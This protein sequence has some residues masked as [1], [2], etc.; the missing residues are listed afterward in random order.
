[1]AIE[2]RQQLKLSQQLIMTPQLQLAIKLLQLSRL[3]LLET[4]HQELQENPALEEALEDGATDQTEEAPEIIP[5][6]IGSITG[7]ISDHKT[8]DDTDWSSLINEYSS[9]GRVTSETEKKRRS[10]LRIFYRPERISAGPSF[11]AISDDI[12]ESGG[13]KPC[14]FD[15]RQS[16][17]RWLS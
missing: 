4:I 6:D 14:Q 8:V 2:L 12:S 11:L 15:Y 3:E 10:Q 17:R 9:S 16:K 7:E 13:G 5:P 1:M